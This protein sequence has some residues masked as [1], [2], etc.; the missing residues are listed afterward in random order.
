MTR[1]AILG[2][3]IFVLLVAGLASLHGALL[4]LAIPV[5]LYWCYGIWEAPDEI[6]LGILRELSAERVPPQTP[7]QV[8]VTITNLA[9]DLE[10]LIIVD[11]VPPGLQIME[12]S[13]RH[14]VSLG[15]SAT[16]QF[17]YSVRGPRGGYPFSSL[18]AEAGDHFGLLGFTQVLRT[19]GHLLVLPTMVRIK[20]MPIRP[21]RTRVYAGMIPARAGGAGVEFFGVRPYQ[22]GD[23]SRRINW[24][25]SA[26]RP[27]DMYSNEFQQERIADVGL[28]LDGRERTNSFTGGRSL[29]EYSVLAAGA[30][31]DALLRQGNRVGLLLYSNYLHWT[32]PGYG[33]LQRERILFAL[34]EAAPG[35]SQIFDGLQ[36][37]PPRLF[38]AESQIVLISPLVEDDYPTLVQ[39]RARGYQV[40]VVA[41]DPVV[42]EA[43]LLPRHGSDYSAAD[44]QLS[45]RVLR[46][47]RQWSLRRVRRAGVH[48]IEWNVSQPFDQVMRGAFRRSFH[49]RNQL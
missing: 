39:L 40:L 34:A 43:G 42:F 28:V 17:A 13:N 18:R 11:Q 5:L 6:H 45:A 2:L 10:E 14:I 4:A 26:R 49:S 33:K 16:F 3:V 15:S 7:V 41:P 31:A 46:M 30:M 38:P 24:Q 35:A 23:S 36:F 27:E 32:L 37:L 21:R 22:A 1:S 9:K 48:V 29:F 19:S 47:E 8:N 25:A 20:D 44:V 12:G